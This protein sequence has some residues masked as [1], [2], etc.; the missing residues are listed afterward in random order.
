MHAKDVM[1]PNVVTVRPDT[2]VCTIARRFIER[3]N[4]AVPIVD[5]GAASSGSSAKAI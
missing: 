3:W 5:Q 4:S 1:T 2:E